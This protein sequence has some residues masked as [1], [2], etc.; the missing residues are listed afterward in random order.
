MTITVYKLD[1]GGRF[2]LQYPAGVLERGEGFVRLEAFFNRDDLDLGYTT[3]K[4]NDRFIETFYSDR[5]YNVFAVYDRD[6]GLLK[7]WYCNVCRPAVLGETAVSC[8]DLALDV[9]VDPS[10]QHLLLDEDEFAV[11]ELSEVE[12]EAGKTAVVHIIHLGKTQQLPF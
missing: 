7:G 12:R 6:D 2:V 4:R 10:G 8:E 9:W 11:L 5:W 1:E 3:F